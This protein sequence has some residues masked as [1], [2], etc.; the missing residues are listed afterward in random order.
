LSSVSAPVLLAGGWTLAAQRQP[1]GYDA[2]RDTISALAAANATDRWVMTAALLGVGACHLVTAA[3]LRPAS[4][5]GRVVLAAGGAAT[6]AVALFP[7][8]FGGGAPARTRSLPPRPSER[9]RCGRPGPR[10]AAP[11]TARSPGGHCGGRSP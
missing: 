3:A 4:L 11:A 10:W 2:V 5:T 1:A 7:L 8:P 6:V 9:S